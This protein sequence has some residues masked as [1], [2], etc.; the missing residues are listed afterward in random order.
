VRPFARLAWAG[1]LLLLVPLAPLSAQPAAGPMAGMPTDTVRLFVEREAAVGG[2]TGVR[3]EV[4]VGELDPRLQLAPCARAEPFV[5]SGARLWG[6]TSIGVRC[7]QGATWSVLVPVT[8]RVFGPALVAARPLPA[9]QPV[10][11]E[12]LGEAEVEW[13]REP[14]GVV[15]RIEQLQ[16]QVPSRPI[17]PGQPIPL[18]AL[19]ARSLVGAGDVVRIQGVGTGF[20]ITMDGVAMN[21]AASGQAVRV[22]TES[23]RIVQG[24]AR[25]T[26][27]VEVAF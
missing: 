1:L 8:I 25:A 23:G 5:P 20:S 22:R 19:R 4:T 9:L 16:M 14:Q 3:V 13:T 6:R 24:I 21:A 27:V 26:R 7:A 17:A 18:A 15:T 11:A 12:D 2:R 10:G